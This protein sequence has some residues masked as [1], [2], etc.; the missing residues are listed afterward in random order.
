VANISIFEVYHYR[1][2]VA[3]NSQTRGFSLIQLNPGSVA[4]N[5][6]VLSNDGL[7]F[8]SSGEPRGIDRSFLH[9]CQLI[10][11]YHTLLFLS[12]YASVSLAEHSECVLVLSVG[13]MPHFDQHGE[14]NESKSQGSEG[15]ENR[16]IRGTAGV[17]SFTPISIWPRETLPDKPSYLTKMLF[18]VGIALFCAVMMW[19]DAPAMMIGFDQ[20]SVPLILAG[21]LA[22]AAQ[23]AAIL[24]ALDLWFV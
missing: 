24:Y 2:G 6:S 9:L 16:E 20:R 17:V 23:S 13:A 22:V 8:S 11:H 15:E 7:G 3:I 14:I 4:S 1:D 18:T 10:A 21:T 12:S 5:K 19:F